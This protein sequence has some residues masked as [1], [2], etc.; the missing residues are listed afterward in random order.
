MR[1]LTSSI[2]FLALLS[3][4]SYG[5]KM[6]TPV[7]TMSRGSE[8]SKAT[9]TFELTEIPAAEVPSDEDAYIIKYVALTLTSHPE[10]SADR[11]AYTGESATGTLEGFHLDIDSTDPEKEEDKETWKIAVRMTLYDDATDK[12][13]NLA[14]LLNDDNQIP[15][16]LEFEDDNSKDDADFFI[17]K[18]LA[19]ANEAPADLSVSPSHYSLSVDW[20]TQEEIS[21]NK[22]ETLEPGGIKIVA[23]DMAVVGA[24]AEIPA[25]IYS[26][27]G[28][29]DDTQSCTY[30]EADAD[31]GHCV[32]CPENGYI[33]YDEL[34][35]TAGFTIKT[36]DG[37]RE[38]DDP[39]IIPK[40]EIEKQYA[41]FATYQPDGLVVSSCLV[42]TPTVHTSSCSEN[43]CPEPE[44]RNPSCFI[45]TAAYGT[46]FHKD[47]DILRW[48]RDT[49]LLK[50]KIG[51]RFVQWYY[52]HSPAAADV[53]SQSPALMSVT[54]ALLWPLILLIS[55][56]KS[57]LLFP[58]LGAVTIGAYWLR[59]R[60][61]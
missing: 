57:G 16:N 61:A 29:E 37:L 35:G 7:G 44:L 60:R 55:G 6:S 17:I 30:T 12:G 47:I 11:V 18:N 46:P 19:V 52:S 4:K 2:F 40:L 10:H 54:R 9:I 15:A 26:E 5:I 50:T 45:A 51:S 41:V 13:K 1:F 23:I 22:G 33:D 32:T 49:Y 59:R 34:A 31:G 28:D 43:D 27:D 42:G 24:T 58:A 20:T 39:V 14:E 25:K 36:K 48:F 8:V 3:T 21:D 38:K 53:I 56:F